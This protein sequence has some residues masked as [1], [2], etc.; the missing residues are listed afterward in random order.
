MIWLILFLSLVFSYYFIL[1]N[2]SKINSK[3]LSLLSV[4]LLILTISPLWSDKLFL[5]ILELSLFWP[6]VF[7]LAGILFAWIGIKGEVRVIL[8]FTNILAIGFYF[9]VYVMG[10][11]GFQQP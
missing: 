4:V 2:E 1:K 5:A 11:F 3:I 8:L 7:G 10:T 6:F 9:V